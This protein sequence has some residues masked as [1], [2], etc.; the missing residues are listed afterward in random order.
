MVGGRWS[1]VRRW[2]SC[3]VALALGLCSSVLAQSERIS[4]QSQGWE[5]VGDL[6]IPEVDANADTDSVAPVPA[7][8]MLN[9]A[10][11]D[12]TP[13]VDLAGY[14]ADR[15]IASLRLDLPGHG[16]STNL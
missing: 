5:L 13:Y 3:F 1:Q 6:T 7:V 16:E 11:G 2:I 10:A 14:L 4:I 12:R 15:G 9:Q 8:L